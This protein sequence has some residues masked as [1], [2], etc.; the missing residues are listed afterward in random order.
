MYRTAAAVL[1]VLLVSCRGSRELSSVELSKLTP[2]LQAL[3]TEERVPDELYDTSIAPDGTKEYGVIVRSGNADE[4]RAAGIKVQSVIGDI[5][6]ARV[7]K[8]QLRT[9]VALPSVKSIDQGNTNRPH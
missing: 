2:G 6:T 5:I 3:L 9:L 1:L 4:L 7:S 8:E